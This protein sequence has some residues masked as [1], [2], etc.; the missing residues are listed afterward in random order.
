MS[1]KYDDKEKYL[2]QYYCD[3]FFHHSFDETDLFAFLILIR[4]HVSDAD[5]KYIADFADL[6]AHRKRNQGIASNAIA[7]AIFYGYNEIN[8][9][10]RKVVKGYQGIDTDKW[11]AEWVRIGKRFNYDFDDRTI[12]EITLCMLSILQFTKHE[13]KVCTSWWKFW[14]KSKVKGM[15]FLLQSDDG[16]L[17]ASTL[18]NGKDFPYINF[19][20]L[21]GLNFKKLYSCRL[22]EDPVIAV[23]AADGTLVLQNNKGE[24]IM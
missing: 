8:V 24:R 21:K 2:I 13:A 5:Q 15:I 16:Q 14:N 23:R 10:G 17:S 7:D 22:I 1:K 4:S 20:L 12:S 18:E 3:K 6:I 19:F 9:N 11:K